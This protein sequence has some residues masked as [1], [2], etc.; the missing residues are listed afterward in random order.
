MKRNII[1]IGTAALV[2]GSATGCGGGSSNSAASASAPS[3]QSM[4]T[5]QA[6]AQAQ[7]PSETT[8][9][10]QVA[11]GALTLTDTS[12]TSDPQSVSVM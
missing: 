10:Y 1:L 7:S 4:D 9:P 5:S 12:D 8:E 3:A 11:D 6:L 2:A